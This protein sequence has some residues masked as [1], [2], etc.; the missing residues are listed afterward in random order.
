MPLF[1]ATD[2]S[3]RDGGANNIAIPSMLPYTNTNNSDALPF[4]DDF[5]FSDEM[6]DRVAQTAQDEI[7]PMPAEWY[8]T[9]KHALTPASPTYS[10]Q[11]IQSPS[12]PLPPPTSNLS[13]RIA[14]IVIRVYRW[15]RRGLGHID[16]CC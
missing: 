6:I 3:T 13:R 4:L 12:S 8:I 11:R 10:S 14:I 2:E 7:G 9:L 16:C 5:D 1:P 15:S